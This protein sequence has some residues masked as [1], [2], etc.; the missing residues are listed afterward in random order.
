MESLIKTSII[1]L[2]KDKV[3]YLQRCIDSL[4]EMNDLSEYEVIIVSNSSEKY[5]TYVYLEQLNKRKNYVVV[6]MNIPF[7]Y[8]KLNNE[9]A[10]LARGEYLLFL[11]NDIQFIEPNT[12]SKLLVTF[13][14]EN[15]GVVG[16]TL[17]Y[18][19][20]T[21]QHVGINIHQA[22]AWQPY[23]NA[24]LEEVPHL[25]KNREVTAVIGACFL[26]S[27]KLFNE[28]QGFNEELIVVL[29]DVDL[30]LKVRALNK[31]IICNK[32]KILHHEGV[33]RGRNNPK[34][35]NAL[36]K[37]FWRGVLS[38][39]DMFDD[40]M[41][42]TKKQ[43]ESYFKEY[44][45]RQNRPV[46]LFGSGSKGD[47][48]LRY[49]ISYN[50]IGFL[51]NDKMKWGQTQNAFEIC[52]PEKILCQNPKP[53]IIISSMYYEEIR[54]QIEKYGYIYMKDFFRLY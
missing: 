13:D 45:I 54:K 1:I 46:Y 7:N 2:T 9:A 28:V 16:A 23:R 29:N 33:S 50:I 26:I 21:I 5:E 34:R 30:C 53:Y 37:E 14:D 31:S 24:T 17:L 52:E 15:V 11:N 25:Q 6:E 49:L 48:A 3:N 35:D 18:P 4:E 40:S 47:T 22:G 8:S 10:K 20:Y 39:K 32:E 51:D 42:I 27:A 19:D 44:N 41:F 38:K 43:L 12:I 36:F